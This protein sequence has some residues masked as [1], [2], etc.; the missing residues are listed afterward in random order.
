[1]R[2][3]REQMKIKASTKL[4]PKCKSSAMV[5]GMKTGNIHVFGCIK[6]KNAQGMHL[7]M[8][9]AKAAWKQYCERESK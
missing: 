7:K 8:R 3:R 4:C 9:D 1:M 6:C 5:M 2:E